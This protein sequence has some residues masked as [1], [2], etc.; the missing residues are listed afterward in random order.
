MTTYTEAIN[1]ITRRLAKLDHML[2]EGNLNEEQFKE[3][4]KLYTNGLVLRAQFQSSQT[5]RQRKDQYKA[6]NV[7]GD[8]DESK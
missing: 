4:T 6:N 2:E 5:L 8:E 7:R 1:D 3:L